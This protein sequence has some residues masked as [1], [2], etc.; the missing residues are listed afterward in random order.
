[1]VD[2]ELQ[3]DELQALREELMDDA[4]RRLNA[5]GIF[6]KTGT[7]KGAASSSSKGEGKGKGKGKG[8][9]AKGK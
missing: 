8:K 6:A 5:Q 9:T 7:G 2:C 1:L 4:W 3:G